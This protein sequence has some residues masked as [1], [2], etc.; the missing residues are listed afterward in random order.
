MSEFSLYHPTV[1]V[2][3]FV[4]RNESGKVVENWN[5]TRGLP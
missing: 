5:C 1:V 3:V 2:Y 4:Y